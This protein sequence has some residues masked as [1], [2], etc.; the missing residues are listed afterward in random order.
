MAGA[1]QHCLVL[2][3]R[4]GSNG[5]AG[6]EYPLWD[7]DVEPGVGREWHTSRVG[8]DRRVRWFSA[9]L[10]ILALGLPTPATGHAVT[11]APRTEVLVVGD[12]LLAGAEPLVVARF[13]AHGIIATVD[14]RSSRALRR[15]FL[16]RHQDRLVV[17]PRPTHRRCRPEGLE[18][19]A[20]WATDG[21]LPR[22]IVVA[23]GTNDAGL[24]PPEQI[25]THLTE[26][27]ALTAGSRLVVVNVA[28]RH[29]T[30]RTRDWNH[31]LQRWCQTLTRCTYADWAGTGTARD[32]R[33]YRPD[34]VHLRIGAVRDRI[35]F[36]VATTR[37]LP[38][39]PT[40]TRDPA[41]R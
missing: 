38:R 32:T 36:L 11:T 26:L 10:S 31:A 35:D 1:G 7:G 33:S 23:L 3:V 9:L 28:K 37:N 24:F 39:T 30:P 21:A 29:M 8:N 15:G 41:T 6:R 12:S 34:G 27:A 40:S 13:A 20:S 5:A 25:Q 4:V 16:C 19:L 17:L 14:A 2:V 18:L 22:T